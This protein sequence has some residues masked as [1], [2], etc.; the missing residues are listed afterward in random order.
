[1]IEN[2]RKKYQRLQRL[3]DELVTGLQAAEIKGVS[4]KAIYAAIKRGALLS[5]KLGNQHLIHR[6][7]L[8]NWVIIGHN[9]PKPKRRRP[10]AEE[11][12]PKVTKE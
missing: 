4:P 10:W 11:A 2:T 9:P 6:R 7:D 12:S 3:E 5:Y 1:M 8:A